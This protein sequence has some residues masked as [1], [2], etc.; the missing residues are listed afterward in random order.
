MLI[1]TIDEFS[2]DRGDLVAAALAFYALLS[3]A[4]MIIIAVAVAGVVLGE[5][6]ARHQVT[7][8]LQGAMG[9]NM[10]HVVDDW[11]QQASDSGGVASVIGV[12]LTLFAASRFAGQLRSAL[13]QVWNVDVKLAEDFRSNVK[14]YFARRLFAFATILAAGLLLLAIIVSRVLIAGLGKALLQHFVFTGVLT[15]VSQI[16]SSFV[17]VSLLSA[18]IFRVVPDTQVRWRAAFCGGLFTSILFT[19]GNLL[20]GIYFGVFAVGAAY[21]AAGSLVVVLLWFYF[22][23]YMFLLGAEFTQVSEARL[24]GRAGRP[25]AVNRSRTAGD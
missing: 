13:N 15:Q 18:V 19:V 11:V 3:I 6:N 1:E 4:P 24:E 17:L 9:A 25:H 5:R 20:V 7:D 22:L 14:S 2:K 10:A 12:S 23:A 21:G 8:L 16:T